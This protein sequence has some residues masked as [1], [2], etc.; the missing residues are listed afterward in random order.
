M[1]LLLILKFDFAS[2]FLEVYTKIQEFKI[3][4]P[5]SNIII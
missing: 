1:Q 2:P 4:F 5:N 3:W